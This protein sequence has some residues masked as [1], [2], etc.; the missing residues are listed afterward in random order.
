MFILICLIQWPIDVHV[1]VACA[2]IFTYPK[3]CGHKHIE[4]NSIQVHR[5]ISHL[6]V[7]SVKGEAMS[8]LI[9]GYI[10]IILKKRKEQERAEAQKAASVVSK[11]GVRMHGHVYARVLH[12]RNTFQYVFV[13]IYWYIYICAC[14]CACLCVS[15]CVYVCMYECIYMCVCVLCEFPSHSLFLADSLIHT[16]T[17]THIHTV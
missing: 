4:Q 9:A 17:H 5:S 3:R 6:D 12:L 10:D 8:Q 15:V 16:H 13:Y 7:F 14:A 11:N 2:H 1:Y